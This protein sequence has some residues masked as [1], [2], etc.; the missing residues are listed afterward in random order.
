MESG[1]TINGDVA[2][3]GSVLADDEGAFAP[4]ISTGKAAVT[5]GFAGTVSSS[6][7]TV[8]FSEEADAILAGYDA[9]HPRLGTTIVAGGQTRYI[10]A[11]AS[12]TECTVTAAPS[13]AWSADAITSVQ[14]PVAVLLK[15]DGTF[16][17]WVNAAGEVYLV[18]GISGTTGTFS[19]AVSATDIS[20]YDTLWVGAGAMI[21]CTTNG[22][23][24]ATQEYGTNDIDL[25]VLAFDGGAT[26]ERAQ[27]TVVMPE[28]WDRGTVKAKFFWTNASGASAADTVE[29]GIKAGALGNDDAI[30]AALGT[31]VTVS[32]TLIAA[33]DL[34]V[35]SATGAITVGGTPALGDLVQFEVYRN[36]DGTD[37]MAEDAWLIGVL[38]QF[39]RNNTISAW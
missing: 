14:G 36:T 5:T 26:E 19:G 21:P 2:V 8:T 7:T 6:G 29:F 11:W 37:D 38:I 16:A 20:P 1:G 4:V 15:S 17:G 34:H 32:D 12:A 18:A 9:S 10:S 3:G 22:A 39:T 35:S 31:A 28:N 25:D 30:D 27:F 13:P 24:P 33:G 23:E